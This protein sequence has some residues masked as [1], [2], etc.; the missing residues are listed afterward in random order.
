[1]RVKAGFGKVLI[2]PLDD[3][4]I[5]KVDG[6]EL[7]IDTSFQKEK[8]TITYGEIVSVTD[9]IDD[10][11]RTEIEAKVGDI[12]YSHYLAIFN[13]IRDDKYYVEDGQF[14]YPVNYE[15]LYCVKRA[16][17]TICLNGYILVKPIKK[18]EEEKIGSVFLPDSMLQQEKASRGIVVSVGNPPRGR[19][20]A[21]CESGQEII[22]RKSS[23]VKIQH[24]MHNTFGEEV[25]RMKADSVLAIID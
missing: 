4:S 11:L 23:S 25:Y 5:I 16:N 18:Y 10:E 7:Y 8:H 17:E 9:Q 24:P 15:S 6:H 2:K 3:T 14:Y 20:S 1:M 19:G 13:A 22:F 12:V 21:P